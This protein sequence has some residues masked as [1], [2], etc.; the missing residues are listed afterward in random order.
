PTGLIQR[1]NGAAHDEQPAAVLVMIHAASD[2]TALAFLQLPEA[3][4][5]WNAADDPLSRPIRDEAHLRVPVPFLVVDERPRPRR[6]SEHGRERDFAPPVP[7]HSQLAVI[8]EFS[9]KV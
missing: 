1:R 4:L 8:V 3:L 6:L 5:V 2:E 9:D 7:G